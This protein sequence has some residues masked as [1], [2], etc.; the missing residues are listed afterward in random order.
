MKPL[1]IAARF[2][3]AVLFVCVVALWVRSHYASDTFAWKVKWTAG[4]V[5]PAQG[6]SGFGGLFDALWDDKRPSGIQVNRLITTS[7]G[8]VMTYRQSPFA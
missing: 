2:L 1:R 8:R 6:N 5:A 3:C 4:P 7:T